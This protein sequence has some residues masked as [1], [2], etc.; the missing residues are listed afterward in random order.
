MLCVELE[1]LIDIFATKPDTKSPTNSGSQA[2]TSANAETKDPHR[3]TTKS[4]TNP[5]TTTKS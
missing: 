4:P 2:A 5:E 1:V 3:H